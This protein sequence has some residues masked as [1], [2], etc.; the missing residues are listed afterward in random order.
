[1]SHKI[2]EFYDV[3]ALPSPITPD[4]IDVME[5]YLD[6]PK[7]GVKFVDFFP[8]FRHKEIVDGLPELLASS[9][10]KVSD[11]DEDQVTA[12]VGAEARGFVLGVMLAQHLGVPFIPFRKSGKL[13]GLVVRREYVT[14]YSK[15]AMELPAQ[16]LTA[17][18]RVLIVDD[19][20]A[21][22][23]TMGAMVHTINTLTPARVHS[24]LVMINLL[25]L[26]KVP[27]GAPLS[28]VVE[29]KEKR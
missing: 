15:D 18:D 27:I 19:L 5:V 29:L 22:G 21:L 8:I 10:A 4:I 25:D 13:P 7:P 11:G 12:V 14:E 28:A 3:K 24:G 17:D 26:P 20:L 16:I 23:G 6:F 9:I 2:V 1:M